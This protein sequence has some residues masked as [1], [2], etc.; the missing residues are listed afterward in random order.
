MA[1]AG[2][3]VT[4]TK[5]GDRFR[6]VL[7]SGREYVGSRTFDT[8][9]EATAWLRREQALLAGGLDPR[10]GRVRVRVVLAEWLQVRRTTV[11]RN[12][13]QADAD[14]V[15]LMPA[16][17][18]AMNIGVVGEREIAR[19][20]EALLADGLAEASVRRYRASLSAL[21]GWAVRERIIGTNPVLATRVPR[22]SAQREEMR[23]FRE[24]ELET[25]W[26][27]WRGHD[28]HLADVML[29]LG[30]TGLRWGE[31]RA[32]VVGDLL[33]VPSP[34]LLVSRS[35]PEGVETK[36]TKGRRSRRVPLADRVLPMVQAWTKDKEPNALLVTT[37]RGA[38]LHR[39][40]VL[41]TLNWVETGKGRRI[42]DLRHTAACLWL[43]RGVDAG[44]VQQWLGHESIGTTNQ[45]LHYLG[46]GADL[47]GLER[48]NFPAGYH[49]GTKPGQR[50]R[51]D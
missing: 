12:T 44:T 14:L 4:I 47:A 9:R 33:E 19:S 39:T 7:K 1:E 23:P 27:V 51:A 20:F 22:S 36:S 31:A 3:V 25:A 18:L 45:Y 13:Y 24:D 37:S 46:T 16:S 35:A 26:Q 38:R 10:Q 48:L 2:G 30:W 17:L 29:F 8:K 11:A 15:R 41:R 6:A 49:G 50:R 40:A 43:A 5:R 34:G 28:E 42:H 32:L 21:F